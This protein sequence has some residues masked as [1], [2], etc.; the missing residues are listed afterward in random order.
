MD[1][2]WRSRSRSPI[3]DSRLADAIEGARDRQMLGAAL[4]DR[5]AR[6]SAEESVWREAPGAPLRLAYQELYYGLESIVYIMEEQIVMM[7]YTHIRTN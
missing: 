7:Y 4:E 1:G 5:L 2:A 3:D 6:A